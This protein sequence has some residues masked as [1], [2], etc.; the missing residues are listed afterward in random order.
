MV[1]RGRWW[2]RRMAYEE[3]QRS[4]ARTLASTL[5]SVPLSTATPTFRC[6]VCLENVSVAHRLLLKGC[7]R[8]AHAAC[9]ECLPTYLRLRIEEGRVRELRC[10]CAGDDGCE[11]MAAEEELQLWLA[12]EVCEKFRRF[13][14]M[15]SD[16]KLRACPCC[17]RLCSPQTAADGSVVADMYCEDCACRFCYYHSNAHAQGLEACAAYERHVVKQQ[18]LDAGLHGTKPC[19]SCGF[20]TEKVS[21]CNHM[22]CKCKANWCWVCRQQL[23]NVGWHYNPANPRGCMQFQ[24]EFGSR[25]DGRMMIFC[26]I[27]GLPAVM[28]SAALVAV[29]VACLIATLPVPALMCCR[30][31]GFKIWIGIAG[32]IVCLPFAIF[33]LVWALI[34]LALWLLLL[35]FGANEVHL[36]F[37]LGVP[38]MTAL[39]IGEG[40][41]APGDRAGRP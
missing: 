20:P 22:T 30:E 3:Q 15:D 18:L 29:F 37:L 33:S 7:G 16:P 36:H 26:K 11:A 41:V 6:C 25:R 21:G 17:S 38:F 31:I 35:P 40:F 28:V 12:P 10:P 4:W 14:Q 34:G 1:V 5:S 23:D 32:F 39:A 24:D 13:V 2:R 8:E 27:L 19:P 9:K